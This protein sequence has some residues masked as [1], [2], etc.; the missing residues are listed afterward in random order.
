MKIINSGQSE[1]WILPKIKSNVSPL[2]EVRIEP[3]PLV[4]DNI[5]LTQLHQL[6]NLKST[7]DDITESTNDGGNSEETTG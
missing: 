3:D 6:N 1:E 7:S 4:A 2:K 5:S